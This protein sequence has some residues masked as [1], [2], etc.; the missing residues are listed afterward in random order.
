MDMPRKTEHEPSEAGRARRRENTPSSTDLCEAEGGA[1]K[2][3]LEPDMLR[4][5]LKSLKMKNTLDDFDF[6]F[7][8]SN[9]PYRFYRFTIRF[10]PYSSTPSSIKPLN[11]QKRWESS[12]T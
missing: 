7:Q 6:S 1:A 8:L 5:N 11:S 10:D 4:E 3:I 12:L 9:I 2:G